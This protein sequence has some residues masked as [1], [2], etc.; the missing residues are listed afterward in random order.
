MI[1]GQL[2]VVFLIRVQSSGSLAGAGWSEIATNMSGAW[3]DDWFRKPWLTRLVSAPYGL[4]PSKSLA[5]V[6]V[7]SHGSFRVSKSCKEKTSPN[8]QTFS[9]CP[10]VSYWRKQVTWPSLKTHERIT[11]RL[12][13]TVALLTSW[14][15]PNSET[16]LG[17]PRPRI[18]NFLQSLSI[19]L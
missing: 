12:G 15:F 17:P 9:K 16:V 14:L 8:M 13:T 19:T 18:K 5:E 2:W 11:Q 1:L 6:V 3:W 7:F 4:E 10:S